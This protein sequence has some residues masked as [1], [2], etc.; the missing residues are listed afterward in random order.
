MFWGREGEFRPCFVLF[1]KIKAEWRVLFFDFFENPFTF[2]VIYGWYEYPIAND[3]GEVVGT[4]GIDYEIK[5]RN[6]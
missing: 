2:V 4:S 3:C 6:T 5:I 1:L